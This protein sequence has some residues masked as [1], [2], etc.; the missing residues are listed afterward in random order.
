LSPF[1]YTLLMFSW[2][3]SCSLSNC[4]PSLHAPLFNV[5]MEDLLQLL[6]LPTQL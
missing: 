3:S 6:Q 1:C 4:Y 5:S 2:T